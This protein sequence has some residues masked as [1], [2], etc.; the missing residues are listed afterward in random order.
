MKPVVI[1]IPLFLV[2]S[3]LVCFFLLPLPLAVRT[4]V[5]VSDLIAAAILGFLLW[6]RFR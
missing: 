3:G 1:I 6:R 5:L 2:M 4:L